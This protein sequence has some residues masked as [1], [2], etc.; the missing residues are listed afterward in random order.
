M[1]IWW[2]ACKKIIDINIFA[3]SIYFTI[4]EFKLYTKKKKKPITFII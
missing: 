1:L 4:S 3:R 2:L